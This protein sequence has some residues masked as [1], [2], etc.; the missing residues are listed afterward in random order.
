M[1]AFLHGVT[2]RCYTQPCG[3]TMLTHTDTHTYTHGPTPSTLPYHP[4]PTHE[5]SMPETI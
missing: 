3:H 1:V 2:G 5:L 4:S